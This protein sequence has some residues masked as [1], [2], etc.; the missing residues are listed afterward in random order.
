[1][2]ACMAGRSIHQEYYYS[3]GN[4]DVVVFVHGILGSPRRFRFLA[5]ELS[6]RGLDCVALL[7]PGHGGSS[8]TFYSTPYEKWPDYV[9][10]RVKAATR[11]HRRVFLVGHSLGGLISLDCAAEGSI[12]GVVLINTPMA[13]RFNFKGFARS[14]K[15]MIAN[16]SDAND[17]ASI[18]YRENCSISG[19][20]LY[21][22]PLW[23][24]QYVSMYRYVRR[25]RRKLK[26]VRAKT[27][28]V[29]SAM[30]ESIQQRSAGIL[31]TGL[32]NAPAEIMELTESYH[33]YLTDK[34]NQRLLTAVERFVAS[35]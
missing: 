19:A 32:V 27:L 24:K 8:R 6:L 9:K 4:A 21:E 28:I 34:D 30:D 29:Q 26:D 23:I 20:R 15:K 25:T 10:L 31:K 5:E 17:A 33:G 3:N 11:T 1:M 22:Y 35:A 12:A 18:A 2:E 13:F 7:L 16:P 14:M